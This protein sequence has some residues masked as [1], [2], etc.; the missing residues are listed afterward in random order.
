VVAAGGFFIQPLPFCSEETLARL[1]QNVGS[2]DAPSK[3]LADGLTPAEIAERVLDGLG[4]AE[5]F[6]VEREPRFGPCTPEALRGRMMTAIASLGK[7]DAKLLLE[8]RG[9]D[10][11]VRC[12]MCAEA[13]SF[14]EEEVLS[15]F[16]DEEGR[17]APTVSTR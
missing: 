3:M 9:G 14:S 10:V 4:R 1:E 17:A 15:T 11:E 6:P 8:E 13:Y 12:E 16:E 2:L 7:E 5:G